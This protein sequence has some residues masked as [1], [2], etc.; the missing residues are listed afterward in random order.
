MNPEPAAGFGPLAGADGV[1]VRRAG[2]DD[3]PALVGLL[4]GFVASHE[5]LKMVLDG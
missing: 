1:V 2:I 5:G 4:V 3:V